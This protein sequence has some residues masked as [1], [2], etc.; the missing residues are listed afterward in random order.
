M[1]NI[2]NILHLLNRRGISATIIGIILLVVGLAIVIL[3]VLFSGQTASSGFGNVLDRLNL[4]K[5]GGS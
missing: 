4:I 1:V 3:L 5:H 2:K